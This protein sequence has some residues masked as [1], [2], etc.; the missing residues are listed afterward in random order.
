M[1]CRDI[2]IIWNIIVS[3]LTSD[4]KVCILKRF[5]LRLHLTSFFLQRPDTKLS[6]VPAT[7]SNKREAFLEDPGCQLLRDWRS[8]NLKIQLQKKKVGWKKWIS[9]IKGEG[10]PTLNAIKN[11]HI[12]CSLPYYTMAGP[13]PGSWYRKCFLT[14]LLS[15][16]HPRFT[17]PTILVSR[18]SW[19]R[20]C[21]ARQRI[22]CWSVV[23]SGKS[24]F[25]LMISSAQRWTRRCT[26]SAVRKCERTTICGLL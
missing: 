9:A 21:F 16:S 3:F 13:G 14:V 23:H 12:F 4:W 2:S 18:L 1:S 15:H 11:F 5:C 7:P 8:W 25:I 6:L 26:F 19:H 10:G 17:T 24:W 22:N 20:T